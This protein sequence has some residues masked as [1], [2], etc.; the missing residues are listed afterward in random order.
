MGVGG[1]SEA[2]TAMW[3][4]EE[5]INCTSNADIVGE[6]HFSSHF[7]SGLQ[8]VRSD[9]TT[10]SV[11]AGKFFPSN[12]RFRGYCFKDCT[13][14]VNCLHFTLLVQSLKHLPRNLS[15]D[16][17]TARLTS[18]ELSAVVERVKSNL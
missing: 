13:K 16:R 5:V 2:F 15:F 7:G 3:Q 12:E 9:D 6:C 14:R 8:E 11:R 17:E 1:S 10:Q 4:R 18:F